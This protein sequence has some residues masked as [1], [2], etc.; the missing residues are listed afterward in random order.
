MKLTDEQK[1][2]LGELKASRGRG[3]ATMGLTGD[4]RTTAHTLCG[5]GLAEW[6]TTI[7]ST[8][9]F[10]ITEKGMKA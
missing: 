5:M 7:G 8:Q 10:R 2:V 3:A 4:R 6:K 1:K 9:F